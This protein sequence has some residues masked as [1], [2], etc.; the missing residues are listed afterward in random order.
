VLP[1]ESA[2]APKASATVEQLREHPAVHDIMTQVPYQDY[3]ALLSTKIAAKDQ[4]GVVAEQQVPPPPPP[5]TK[6]TRR[7]PHPVLIG[8]G[9]AP[10]DPASRVFHP[11][12]SG[13]SMRFN[14]PSG[15]KGVLARAWRGLL[16]PCAAPPAQEMILKYRNALQARAPWLYR[17]SGFTRVD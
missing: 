3:A 5:R 14:T 6:W 1:K 15:I 4:R 2:T 16:T 13:R 8:H 10:P 9:P 11:R 12:A 7:V 17:D